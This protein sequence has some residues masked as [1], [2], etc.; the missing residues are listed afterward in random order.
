MNELQG[1]VGLA[2]LKKL[3]FV[4][5]EQRNNANLISE[6]ITDLPIEMRNIPNG[7]YETADA[8]VFFRVE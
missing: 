1:A 3:E 4:V 7:S 5:S 2:Q 8:L 6:K